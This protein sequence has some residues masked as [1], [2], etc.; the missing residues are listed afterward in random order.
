MPRTAKQMQQTSVEPPPPQEEAN[1]RI[2]ARTDVGY[3]YHLTFPASVV[4]DILD[5]DVGDAYLEIPIPPDMKNSGV[6]H[7]YLHTTRIAELDIHDELPEV[8]KSG[9]T[10]ERK[11]G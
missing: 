2:T 3:E 10:G 7:R 1:I 4:R 6:K 8:E 11:V 9:K 5:P